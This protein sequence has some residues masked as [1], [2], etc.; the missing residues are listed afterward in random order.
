MDA[1]AIGPERDVRQDV[2]F[3]LRQLVD[4]A[5]RALSPGVNDPTTAVQALDQVHDILRRLVRRRFPSPSRLDAQGGLRLVL[6]RPDWA[7]IVRLALDE[8]RH[9]GEGAIQVARRLRFLLEDLLQVAPDFRRPELQRQL[10]LLEASV[11]RGFSD[12]REAAMAHE[13]SAQGHGPH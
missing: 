10:S 5:E 2:A 3:G 4:V 11:E 6:P 7:A 8:I 12:G 13:A 9:S 1:V